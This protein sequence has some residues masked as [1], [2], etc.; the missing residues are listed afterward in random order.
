MVLVPEP[1]SVNTPALAVKSPAK[2]KVEEP[3]LPFIFN[4]PPVSEKSPATSTVRY[5]NPRFPN[6]KRTSCL[7]EISSN[8]QH[9]RSTAIR[10][11]EEILIRYC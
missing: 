3:E 8:C 11:S 6:I 10:Q 4:V 7:A 1:V 5:W 2:F 9:I